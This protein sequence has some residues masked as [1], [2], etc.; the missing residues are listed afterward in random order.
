MI[1][2]F[3]ESRTLPAGQL[4]S[5]GLYV[6]FPWCLQ[7]CPY[8]DF[9]SHA[10]DAS[11]IPEAAY[12]EALV[13]DLEA[14]LPLL[15]GRVPVSLFLGGGT[16]S[17]FSVAGLEWFLTAIRKRLLLP[18][19][20][21]ITLEANPGT[22]RERLADERLGA[23]RQIGINR[24]SLGV[25]SFNAA[26]LAALGRIHGRAEA[27]LAAELAARHFACRNLDLMYGLPGQT[28]EEAL[29]DLETA[30][31]C[32]PTHLSCYQLT[33]EPN[34]HFAAFPPDLPDA[35]LCAEMGEAIEAALDAAGFQHYETSAFARP[36]YQ[37]RHNRNYWEFGDYLGI[38]AGAHGKLTLPDG[39]ILRQMRWKHP[40][41]YLRHIKAR[42]P[43]QEAHRVPPAERPIEFLMNALRLTEGFD[44]AR[45]PERTG[46]PLAAILP[47]LEEAAHEGWLDIRDSRVIP[48]KQ[49]RRF[50]NRLLERFL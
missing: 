46:L 29:T 12:L 3:P 47:R 9:N 32:A 15:S 14:S 36:G 24:I 48:S 28:L 7:K 49:G 39:S 17:L 8:C 18:P 33:V 11:G 5:V 25:Q 42:D 44:L 19:D 31:R 21:E 27:L 41:T 38:G 22:L 4:P 10:V 50:L 35:D 43:V 20:V 34:T 1:R 13:A 45:F 37:C 26:H 6:H 16:P 40:E 23:L 30:L 2:F